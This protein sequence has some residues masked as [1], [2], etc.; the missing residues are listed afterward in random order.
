MLYGTVMNVIYVP[1]KINLIL[2]LM[3]PISPL[4]DA[5]LTLGLAAGTNVLVFCEPPRKPA[6]MS[7]QR[8]LNS[9]LELLDNLPCVHTMYI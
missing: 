1:R 8:I 5:A 2:D 6:L 3:F 7:D 9:A 4:P